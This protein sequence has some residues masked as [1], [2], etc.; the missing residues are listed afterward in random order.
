MF[1]CNIEANVKKILILKRPAYRG[2]VGDATG[3]LGGADR[4][5]VDYVIYKELTKGL[6]QNRKVL[7]S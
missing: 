4:S 3:P 7:N 5:V 2:V 6:G 1:Y